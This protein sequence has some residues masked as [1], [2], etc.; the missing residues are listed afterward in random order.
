LH[1]A[2]VSAVNAAVKLALASI[3]FLRNGEADIVSACTVGVL[4]ESP[5]RFGWP[6]S[7][8]TNTP[9]DACQMHL[10]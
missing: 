7:H 4:R 1:L 5:V 6:I 2:A 3:S 10:W 8:P 9:V